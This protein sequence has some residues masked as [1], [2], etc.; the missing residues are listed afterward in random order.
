MVEILSHEMPEYLARRQ[1]ARRRDR[2]VQIVA[3]VIAVAGIVVAGRFLQPLN[4]IRLENQMVIDPDT[5]KGLPPIETLLAKTGTFRALAIDIAF[6]RAEKL[7]EEGK[8]YELR[9]LADAICRLAPRFP[10]VWAFNAWN[11]AYNISVA[12]YTA[13]ERWQWVNNGIQ[14]LRDM[15]IQYN[16]KSVAL[17]KEL[18]WIYWHK[19]GDFLDD[20]HWNYKAELAVEMERVLGPPPPAVSEQE[21]IEWFRTIAQAPRDL[22]R[23]L[24]DDRQVA[25]L[26]QRLDQVGLYPDETLLDFI[27]Q[28]LRDDLSV[29]RYLEALPEDERY[30]LRAR[31]LALLSDTGLAAPRERLLAALR[32]WVLRQRYHMNVDWMLEL[33]E[34]YGPIDWRSP[35]GHALYWS[36]WG[37]KVTQGQ[38]N[39]NP[40]DSMNTVRYIMM[41]LANMVWRGR[42]ILTPD[43]AHPN[44]SYIEL[45]PDTRFIRHLHDAYIEL[46]EAQF[47]DWPD[48]RPG[49]SA[50]SY[51]VG[52]FNFLLEAVRQLYFEGDPNSRREAQ[53]YYDYLRRVNRNP[54]G[55]QKEIYLVPLE[56]FVL[57][58]LRDAVAGFKTANMVVSQLIYQSFRELAEGNVE[59]AVQLW[60]EAKKIYGIYMTD[61]AGDRLDRRKLERLS[62]LRADGLE[63]FLAN[64]SI[65]LVA[66]IRVWRAVEKRTRQ[67]VWDRV[68]GLLHKLCSEHDPP[69]DGARAFPE[70]PGMEEYR[71]NPEQRRERGPSDVSEGTK[72]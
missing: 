49:E 20:Y 57:Q 59:R 65:P 54:D 55:T 12:T 16:P 64:R 5:V 36:S 14:L 41:A 19:I 71:K 37:D 62:I 22:E 10:S 27:A 44:Q 13:E 35:Y 29:E 53:F 4:D 6:I 24:A 3:G 72:L 51:R 30:E 38:I 60:E 7:K 66:K 11:Q 42:I 33:M 47:G 32:S 9:E 31:R 68:E 25:D 45:L 40:N 70:P 15:G 56:G 23:L 28:N 63:S 1:A 67:I 58:D 26:V 52:H 48:F 69:L 61:V 34:K 2:L 39:L 8:Y 43:F 18:A 21:T 46:S 50:G 17:Y